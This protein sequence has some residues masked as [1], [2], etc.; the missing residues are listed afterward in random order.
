MSYVIDVLLELVEN[1]ST[2]MR[3][4]RNNE[5]RKIGIHCNRQDQR[6]SS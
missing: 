4:G 6:K 5:F 1:E 3:L 2:I